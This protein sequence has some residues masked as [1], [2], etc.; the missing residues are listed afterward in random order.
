MNRREFVITSA[1]ACFAAAS[2][3]LARAAAPPHYRCG[4]APSTPSEDIQAIRVIEALRAHGVSFRYQTVIPVRFHIIHDGA[5]GYVSHRRLKAQMA[6][7][8]RLYAPAGIAFTIAD[9]RLHENKAWFTHEPGSRAEIE[10]K[11]ELG[12]DSARTLNIYTAAPETAL[13]GFATVPWSLASAPERDGIVIHHES[14]PERTGA[15][16]PSPFVPGMVAVHQLGH[17]AGGL[18]HAIE[19][20]CETQ[21]ACMISFAPEQYD[22]IRDLVGYYRFQLSPQASRSALLAQIRKSIE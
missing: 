15:N 1:S 7:L 17:W 6:L 12:K 22:R 9:A 21:G 16:G 14:L 11:T 3:G 18:S 19:D 20:S 13:S 8:N 5:R 10:M 2:A 4:T